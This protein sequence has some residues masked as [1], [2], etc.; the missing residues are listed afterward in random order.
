MSST[1]TKT[2]LGQLSSL[3]GLVF[4]GATSALTGPVA[5]PFKGVQ[6][7]GS[8]ALG[9]TIGRLLMLA[10]VA[11]GL[12]F[13]FREHFVTHE[14]N[15]WRAV[16]TQKQSIINSKV[17]YVNH[18]TTEDQSY[19][20]AIRRNVNNVFRVVADS[21]WRVD[22]KHPVPAST[23]SLI[24][25]TRHGDGEVKSPG[26]PADITPDTND[27]GSNA[28]EGSTPNASSLTGAGVTN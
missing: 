8:F 20:A 5:L 18:K 19:A 9:S 23:I 4:K 11:V 7:L 22:D 12:G 24:N 3:P 16:V 17:A 6:M 13:M 10:L 26:P 28:Y 1:L 25:E 14:R 2:L 27:V 21:L 15:E